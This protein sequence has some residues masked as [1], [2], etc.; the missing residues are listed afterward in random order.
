MQACRR[1]L[2]L[3]P[4]CNDEQGSGGPALRW[5]HPTSP[6]RKFADIITSL[7]VQRFADDVFFLR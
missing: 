3:A 4:D 2:E 6:R 5:S 7:P 1:R